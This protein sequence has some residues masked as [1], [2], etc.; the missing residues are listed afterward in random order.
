MRRRR[1]CGSITTFLVAL[2][3]QRLDLRV[4]VADAVVGRL[5]LLLQV[6]AH[7]LQLAQLKQQDCAANETPGWTPV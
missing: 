6:F 7:I 1:T 5:Q 4:S 2:L 3:Q